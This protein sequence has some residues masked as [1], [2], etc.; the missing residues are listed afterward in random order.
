MSDYES[1]QFPNTFKA[2]KE[3]DRVFSEF[4]KVCDE[5]KMDFNDK[6]IITHHLAYLSTALAADCARADSQEIAH[7]MVIDIIKCLE[8]YLT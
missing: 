5:D 1:I 6:M 7:S 3:I 2:I 8:G 4:C